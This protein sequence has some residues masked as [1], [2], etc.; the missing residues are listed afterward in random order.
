MFYATSKERDSH[1]KLKKFLNCKH[2]DQK[3]SIF[4]VKVRIYKKIM[5]SLCQLNDSFIKILKF[6]EELVGFFVVKTNPICR[7]IY[8]FI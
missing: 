2:H 5:D 6:F 1:K 8:I 4:F 7:L 3:I